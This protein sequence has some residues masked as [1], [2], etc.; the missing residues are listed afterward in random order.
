MSEIQ[1]YEINQLKT[2]V[3]L[4]A[5]QMATNI[6]EI[7]RRLSDIREM[8][9]HGQW[10]V[11]VRQNLPFSRR[12]ANQYIKAYKEFGNSS[13]QLPAKKM[14]LLLELPA[15]EREG[16]IKGN[17]VDEMTTRELQQAV[18]EKKALEEENRQLK[19]RKPEVIIKE[20]PTLPREFH[21]MK[22]DLKEFELKISELTTER[23]ELERQAKS[24][25][26]EA[27]EY[28]KLKEQLEFLKRQKSDLARQIDSA[29]E[30]SRLAV[31]LHETLKQELAPIKFSRCM[32]RL[33]KSETAINNLTEI[34][35]L[36]EEWLVE[37]KKYLPNKNYIDAEVMR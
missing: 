36:V 11:W 28:A 35:D 1:I 29:T 12:W 9:E 7:G 18:K 6:L 13:T 20:V 31:R 26:N 37:I 23:D 2:E 15:E 25:D 21:R 34:V 33:D 22:R 19:N 32:E 16:F 24:N 27:K 8:V 3:I 4:L 30:L 17:R 10:D 5:N 14:F